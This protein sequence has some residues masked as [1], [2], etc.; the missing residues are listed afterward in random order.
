MCYMSCLASTPLTSGAPIPLVGMTIIDR[1]LFLLLPV[2][3]MMCRH[4]EISCRIS[5]HKK[6]F[7]NSPQ[8]INS[9]I[10][11]QT[12]PNEVRSTRP[13]N[14]VNRSVVTVERWR[15]NALFI[16]YQTTRCCY[17]TYVWSKTDIMN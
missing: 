7:F 11:Q 6:I 16:V 9:P 15:N 2:P 4:I 14:Y 8:P 17:A 5:L 12:E 10:L 13:V 3:A 1:L